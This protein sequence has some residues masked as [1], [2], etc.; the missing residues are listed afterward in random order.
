LLSTDKQRI[1]FIEAC[2]L[3]LGLRVNGKLL[4]PVSSPSSLHLSCARVATAESILIALRRDAATVDC[5]EGREYIRGENDTFLLQ[6]HGR[7]ATMEKATIAGSTDSIQRSADYDRQAVTDSVKNLI[8]HLERHPSL[9][10]TPKFDHSVYY[11]SLEQF[12][13]AAHKPSSNPF[14]KSPSTYGNTLLHSPLI[15]STST[16]LDKNYILLP[17]LPAGTV[18]HATTQFAGRGRGTNVWLSPPGS[19]LFSVVVPHELGISNRGLAPVVL[20]QYLAAMAVIQGIEQYGQ[21]TPDAEGW[22]AVA[23]CVRLKWPNDIYAKYPDSTATDGSEYVK[24]GGILV[25]TSYSGGHYTLIVGI[26]L[27]VNNDDGCPTT[28][29]L[30]I[31]RHLGIDSRIRAPASAYRPIEGETSTLASSSEATVSLERLQASILVAL[32]GL[33][34]NFCSNGWDRNIERMYYDMWLHTNQVVTVRIEDEEQQAT[35]TNDNFLSKSD[36]KEWQARIKG[37]T[38]DYGMLIAEEILP[39]TAS[40]GQ[41]PKSFELRS[42]MN[43]FDFM[44]GL[45][46]KKI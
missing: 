30:Q 17:H 28:S 13:K 44:Q 8:F 42:D 4:D 35:K 27:N 34:L 2:L 41:R 21:E 29:L 20:V 38:S 46:R 6:I 40:P 23:K 36:T 33:H 1:R 22:K 24:I 14:A 39:D 16:L 43:S 25:T 11:G 12:Q 18:V 26:G 45:V 19:L 10:T 15:S 3:K 31:A 32:E 37:I 9:T 5:S 7:G